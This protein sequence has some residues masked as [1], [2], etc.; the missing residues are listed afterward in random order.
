[1]SVLDTLRGRLRPAPGVL[2]RTSS[3][4][5]TAIAGSNGR[6]PSVVYQNVSK[7]NP[8]K[9][10][11]AAVPFPI[12]TLPVGKNIPPSINPQPGRPRRRSTPN[13]TG[14]TVP[15]GAFTGRTK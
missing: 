10:Q 2:P 4:A 15:A 6:L 3:P 11:V 8:Y 7:S 9:G 12:V 1:M 5:E 14:Y 13:P